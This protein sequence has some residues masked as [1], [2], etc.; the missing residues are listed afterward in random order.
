MSK[1]DGM[2]SSRATKG[3]VVAVG[4]DPNDTRGLRLKYV[5]RCTCPESMSATVGTNLDATNDEKPGLETVDVG[6]LKEEKVGRV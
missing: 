2:M 6:V 4:S 3:S 1:D 5:S